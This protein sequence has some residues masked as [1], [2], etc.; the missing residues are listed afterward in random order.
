MALLPLD[1]FKTTLEADIK[2]D[3]SISDLQLELYNGNS[4]PTIS[5]FLQMFVSGITQE[6]V[7][8]LKSQPV[9]GSFW[10]ED[11]ANANYT[12]SGNIYKK[13]DD[14]AILWSTIISEKVINTIAEKTAKTIADKIINYIKDNGEV[15]NVTANIPQNSITSVV[16]GN[17]V[18]PTS[19]VDVSQ[20]SATHGNIQ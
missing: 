18:G 5:G 10:L 11:K 20:K 12:L 8:L 6:S 13:I 1:T 2:A 19:D 15:I 3:G 16:S 4:V 14:N 17:I 9:T 7:N